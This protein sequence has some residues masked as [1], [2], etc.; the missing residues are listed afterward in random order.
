MSR[1]YIYTQR[2]WFWWLAGLLPVVLLL[3]GLI[4]WLFPQQLLTVDDGEVR[5]D[6]LIVLGGG[7]DERPTRAAE[8]FKAGAAPIILVSGFG[9]GEIN[10]RILTQDGVPKEAI[11]RESQARSTLENARLSLPLLRQRGARRVIIVTSWYHSR[12]ALACFRH[13]GPDIQFYSRPAYRTYPRPEW[14]RHG[15]S[16]Y[17]RGEYLKLFGYW[18]CY[19]V[20]PW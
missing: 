17:I 10:E 18:V 12:R 7:T 1:L 8:L 11:L 16:N 13:V 14:N 15:T 9:D 20:A 3:V 4:G 6:A 19:G 5:A 2:R